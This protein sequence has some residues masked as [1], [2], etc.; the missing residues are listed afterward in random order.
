MRDS[1]FYLYW[2]KEQESDIVEANSD[3][4]EVSLY[5]SFPNSDI[6]KSRGDQFISSYPDVVES[7]SGESFI[8]Y[9]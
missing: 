8:V 7:P 6:P 4:P 5:K 9:W 2:G 3:F 1:K